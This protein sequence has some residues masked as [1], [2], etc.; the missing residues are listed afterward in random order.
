LIGL[1][2]GNI[3]EASY[4]RAFQVDSHFS[5]DADRGEIYIDF[6]NIKDITCIRAD[7]NVKVIRYLVPV[8]FHNLTTGSKGYC[9]YLFQNAPSQ[10]PDIWDSKS[11]SNKARWYGLSADA[12]SR[13]SPDDWYR[14]ANDANEVEIVWHQQLGVHGYT[15]DYFRSID[16]TRID[17]AL[18]EDYAILLKTLMYLKGYQVPMDTYIP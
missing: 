15:E 17:Y 7:N 13:I 10:A 8:M 14:I 3:A 6:E 1:G 12:W 5:G 4:Q 18:H 11:I 9:E 16:W 2:A